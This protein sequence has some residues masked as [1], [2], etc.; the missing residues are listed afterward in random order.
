MS[1]YLVNKEKT[2]RK[3]KTKEQKFGATP[4][5]APKSTTEIKL[6]KEKNKRRVKPARS[7]LKP[8]LMFGNKRYK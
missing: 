6:D 3:M 8:N 5:P 7:I 1:V 4:K 2:M